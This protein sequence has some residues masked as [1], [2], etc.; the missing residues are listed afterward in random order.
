MLI[1][2]MMMYYYDGHFCEDS[3][4]YQWIPSQQNAS[5]ADLWLFL[6]WQSR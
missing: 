1:I 3:I 4:G 2:Y 6:C 5:D